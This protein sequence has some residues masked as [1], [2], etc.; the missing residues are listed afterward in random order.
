MHACVGVRIRSKCG[1]Y[2]ICETY[3]YFIHNSD[4]CS[5]LYWLPYSPSPKR[6]RRPPD[7]SWRNM[8]LIFHYNTDLHYI[9]ITLTATVEC[10]CFRDLYA[11]SPAQYF[12]FCYQSVSVSHYVT[13]ND[14]WWQEGCS[15]RWA[16]CSP[17]VVLARF[18]SQA[19]ISSH[20]Q[21]WYA[22]V[23]TLWFADHHCVQWETITQLIFH[24]RILSLETWL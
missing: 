12:F 7:V 6:I 1:C 11:A 8:M 3:T 4:I 24:C 20:P 15:I 14:E 13:A 10:V 23:K 9:S 22:T 17:F 19:Q 16:F 5:C 2:I 21:I 18:K